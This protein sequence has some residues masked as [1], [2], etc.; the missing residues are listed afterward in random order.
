MTDAFRPDAP[1]SPVVRPSPEPP[2]VMLVEDDDDYAR[3]VERALRAPG[4]GFD[5]HREARLGSALGLVEQGRFDA[6]VVDLSLPDGAGK[7]TLGSA[8]A[9]ARDL[10]VLILTGQDDERMALAAIRAGAQ[11]YLV[12]QRVEPNA[13]PV[14]VLHAIERHRRA[15]RGDWLSAI[16]D[17]RGASRAEGG[18]YDPVTGLPNEALLVDRL[19]QALARAERHVHP[20]AVIVARY[21]ELDLVRA[22]F[23]D[24]LAD[25]ILR[26]AARRLARRVRAC[27]TVARLGPNGFAMVIEECWAAPDLERIGA[28]LRRALADVRAS[29]L[30]GLVVHGMGASLGAA[31]FPEEGATLEALLEAAEMDRRSAV[32]RAAAASPH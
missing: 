11:D 31:L 17:A 8:C 7:F 19:E 2:R 5:V 23:G 3:L 18:L 12:K 10:P 25:E 15:R 32:A 30:H 21:D 20:V 13:L 29:D 16:R 4:V 14:S 27:D 9:L 6:M 26:A 28:G 1:P 22:W 24:P